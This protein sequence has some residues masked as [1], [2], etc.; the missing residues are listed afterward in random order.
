MCSDNWR[1]YQ[2]PQGTRLGKSIDAEKSLAMRDA[3]GTPVSPFKSMYEAWSDQS[4]ADELK[5]IALHIGLEASIFYF[6]ALRFGFIYDE[7]GMYKTFTF[8]LG[9]GSETM[10][11]NF[12]CQ[13]SVYFLR[14]S[15]EI[16]VPVL[17]PI[18]SPWK[19]TERW[20]RSR[21]CL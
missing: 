1:V 9:L 14:S 17:K 19:R 10:R 4:F 15:G 7:P 21:R 18:S 8:G 11:A 6:S 2:L 13:G 12:A 16:R 5:D 20:S 3:F